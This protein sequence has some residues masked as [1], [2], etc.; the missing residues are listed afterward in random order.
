MVYLEC[1]QI[2]RNWMSLAMRV[3]IQQTLETILDFLNSL[4]NQIMK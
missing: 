4:N 2:Y 3:R 1:H